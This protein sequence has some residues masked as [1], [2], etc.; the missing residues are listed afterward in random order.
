L[1]MLSD[2]S[3]ISRDDLRKWLTQLGVWLE[4]VLPLAMQDPW[5]R[6][7]LPEVYHFM[8][9]LEQAL[10]GDGLVSLALAQAY[11]A[12][13]VPLVQDLERAV[14]EPLPGQAPKGRP[15][16]AGDLT[17]DELRAKLLSAI[18]QLRAQGHYP[19]Q[20]KVMAQM[21]LR[22][23]TRRAREWLRRLKIPSWEALLEQA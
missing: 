16:G 23:D 3:P 12:R 2:T 5:P 20:A 1:S 11:H 4:R 6:D 10:W 19:S 7:L 9:Q 8:G 18:R 15:K 13:L 22:G 17:D 14:P 21:G